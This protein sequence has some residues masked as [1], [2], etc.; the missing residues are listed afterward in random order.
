MFSTKFLIA[1]ALYSLVLD[2]ASGKP[3]AEGLTACK[4]SDPKLDECLLNMLRQTKPQLMQGNPELNLPPLDPVHIPRVSVYKNLQDIR[5]TGELSNLTAKGASLI[6]FKSLKVNL[7]A[8]T[9]DMVIAIPLVTFV[10]DFD[11]NVTLKV[12]PMSV[13][14]NGLCDG[15]IS[16]SVV[17]FHANTEVKDGKLKL[18]DIKINLN[19]GDVEVHIIKSQNPA[20]AQTTSQFFNTNKRLVLDLVTPVAEDV[21]RQ[22]LLRFGNRILSN[23]EISDLLID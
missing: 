1:F 5:V 21:V 7:R 13:F 22:M 15:K 14:G 19:L 16:H 8:N 12:I 23:V 6:T 10:T 20:L 3:F 11:L 4:R 17:R 18:N 9:W 2:T